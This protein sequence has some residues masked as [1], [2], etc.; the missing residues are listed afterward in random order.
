MGQGKLSPWGRV[1]GRRTQDSSLGGTLWGSA[2][3]FG[4]CRA[5]QD[6]VA[7]EPWIRS[8]VRYAE[9]WAQDLGSGLGTKI[10]KHEPPPRSQ[11]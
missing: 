2:L 11:G 1:G 5:L 3:E 10:G 6:H 8:T 4:P 7:I 9:A